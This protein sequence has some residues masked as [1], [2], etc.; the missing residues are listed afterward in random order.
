[1]KNKEKS[2]KLKK[3]RIEH[4]MRKLEIKIHHRFN[5]ISW[6]AKAMGSIKIAV[7]NQGENG[8]EYANE[9][10][11]TVGDT[12][13]KF[14]IADKLYF[15]DGVRTKG[16]ITSQ[17]SAIENNDSM[18]KMML[19][20]GLID[21]S[22]NNFHFCKDPDIPDHEKVV[23]NKHDPYIEAIIAAV[24]YDSN[25]ETTKKWILKWL[26]PVLIKY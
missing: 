23:C 5:D 16:E 25:F 15:K 19:N 9:S 20:E 17:K 11:A 4:E 12:I 14:V 10:L 24:Y 3:E 7:P 6:L 22:Y 21:Y 1:M 18:H 26:L 2:Q 8:S 13:L